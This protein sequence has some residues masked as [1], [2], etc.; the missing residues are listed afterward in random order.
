[1]ALVDVGNELVW[2][3]LKLYLPAGTELSSCYRPPQAQFDFIVAKARKH[4]YEFKRRPVLEDAASWQAA[5]QFVR[6]QG[7]QVAA[8]GKSAHQKGI[9]YDLTGPNL[10]AIEAGVRK[11]VGQKRITLAGPARTALLVEKKNH[12]V[13]V[14]IQAAILD[15]EPTEYA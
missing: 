11:A 3:A 14:E 13:H 12:C 9:A 5:L 10:F 4:G 8:P 2:H 1:M 7:Y 15:Y 6:S